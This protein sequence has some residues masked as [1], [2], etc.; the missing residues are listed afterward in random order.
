MLNMKDMCTESV[1]TSNPS[2][3][4][5]I[6]PSFGVLKLNIGGSEC[7][8]WCWHVGSLNHVNLTY[9]I[10]HWLQMLKG[11]SI[12]VNPRSTNYFTDSIA[13]AGSSS[14]VDNLQWEIT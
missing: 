3:Q 6:K 8:Q 7:H 14:S 1:I 4:F 2:F 9:D 10:R 11:I 5:W 12:N 13:K